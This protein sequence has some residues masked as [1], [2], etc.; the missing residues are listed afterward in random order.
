MM[1]D[2]PRALNEAGGQDPHGFTDEVLA[3][4]SGSVS[5]TTTFSWWFATLLADLREGVEGR[6]GPAP[7][8]LFVDRSANLTATSSSR[9]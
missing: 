6:V 3:A 4:N 8:D 9:P 1:T 2:A 7:G 5:P